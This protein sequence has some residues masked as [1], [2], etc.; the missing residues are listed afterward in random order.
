MWHCISHAR[1]LIHPCS[2]AICGAIIAG[3][4][5][6]NGPAR[7]DSGETWAFDLTTT[8]DDVFWT[9]PTAVDNDAPRYEGTYEITLIEVTGTWMGIPVGPVD[10]TDEVPEED[11]SGT[12]IIDGPPPIVL[13]DDSLVYPEP[14]EDPSIAAN[15]L[16][17][18]DTAGFGQ[19]EVTDVVLGEAEVETDF[20]TVTIQITSVRVA[21]T[22][23]VTPLGPLGD[24]TGNGEVGVDDLF[25]LLGDWGNCDDPDNCPADL[26][27]SGDVGV[28][29]LFILLGNWT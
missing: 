19:M 3:A 18:L 20:G 4:V 6:M 7:A 12:D 10:V 14:P 27:G 16:I 11:R 1:G 8:G 23:E 28:D 17:Y 5:L 2:R 13:L 26:N 25:I 22:V 9:S 15:V 29:D 21:G 24:L